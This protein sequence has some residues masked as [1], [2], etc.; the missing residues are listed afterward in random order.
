[1]KSKYI[2]LSALMLGTLPAI[3][4]SSAPSFEQSITP[5]DPESE[6]SVRTSLYGWAQGL[7]GDVGVLGNTAP[8]D[9][10]FDD[11]LENLDIAAMGAVEISHG[12]WSFLADVNYAK[13]SADGTTAAGIDVDVEQDQFLGNFLIIYQIVSNDRITLD[14][15]AG[16][17]VNSIGLDLDL[18]DPNTVGTDFSDSDRKTWVDPIVGARFQAELS[19]K[20]FFRAVGDIGGFGIASDLTWQALAGFGYR[21][22]SQCAAVLGYRA[23][24]TDYTDG[25][26]TYDV[27]ASGPVIG[28]QYTF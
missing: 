1:M 16:A 22:N 18:D 7:D 26:F 13:V 9:M 10:G 23:I 19:E 8:V 15:F 12:R 27:V 24:G 17:R 6:W 5:A 28:L 2:I 11:I 14:L 4:G 20:W 21:F 25:G 3:A